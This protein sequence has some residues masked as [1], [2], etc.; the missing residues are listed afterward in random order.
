[1]PEDYNYQDAVKEAIIRLGRTIALLQY[2]HNLKPSETFRCILDAYKGSK[3]K[4]FA[5]GLPG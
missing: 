5:S 4:M 2:T 3:E 1:M